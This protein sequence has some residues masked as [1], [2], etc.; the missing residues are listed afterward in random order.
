GSGE[1]LF[2]HVGGDLAATAAAMRELRQADR[3]GRFDSRG[4]KLSRFCLFSGHWFAKPHG[5][6][7]TGAG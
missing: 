3:F 5:G 7:V 1:D 2:E 4:T 6:V